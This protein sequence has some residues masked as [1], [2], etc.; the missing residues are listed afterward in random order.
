MKLLARIT[1]NKG[2]KRI[3]HIIAPWYYARH[4]LDGNYIPFQPIRYMINFNDYDAFV[5]LLE[6]EMFKLR[7][8]SVTFNLIVFCKR[9]D[10]FEHLYKK[11]YRS[12]RTMPLDRNISM[13]MTKYL[14][15]NGH[16]SEP[17]IRSNAYH[18]SY[19]Q[20]EYFKDILI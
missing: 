9:I 20:K 1:R 5:Y 18:M 3:A 13:I 19:A 17:Y 7:G 2:N 4:G 11:G 8:I 12:K 15:E 10:M 6:H 16:Y 14:Y